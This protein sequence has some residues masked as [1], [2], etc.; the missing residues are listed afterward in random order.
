MVLRDKQGEAIAVYPCGSEEYLRIEQVLEILFRADK[1]ALARLL[2]ER[3]QQEEAIDVQV[4]KCDKNIFRRALKN[5][6]ND[7]I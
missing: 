5:Q 2:E 1:R 3:E 6:L 7:I 4:K